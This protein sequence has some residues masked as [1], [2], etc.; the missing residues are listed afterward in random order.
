M[1]NFLCN[2]N[3]PLLTHPIMQL[4]LLFPSAPVFRFR[5]ALKLCLFFLVGV[6]NLQAQLTIKGLI[7]TEGEVRAAIRLIGQETFEPLYL[8]AVREVNDE[9]SLYF[10]IKYELP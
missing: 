10:E 3:E 6:S 9:G 5:I 7:Y 1:I 2:L 8:S 4:N